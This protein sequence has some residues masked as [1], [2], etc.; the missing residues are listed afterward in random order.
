VLPLVDPV[1][2]YNTPRVADRLDPSACLMPHP[3]PG[4]QG[5]RAMDCSLRSIIRKIRKLFCING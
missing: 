5:T 3:A 2:S 4:A 1:F